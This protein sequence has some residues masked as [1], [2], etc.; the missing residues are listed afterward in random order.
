MQRGEGVSIEGFVLQ[1]GQRRSGPANEGWITRVTGVDTGGLVTIGE[2]VI[3]PRTSGPSLHVHSR[4]DEVYLVRHGVLTVQLGDEWFE[5]PADGLAW[6]PRGIPHAFANLADEPV[7]LNG[8]IL[9]AGLERMF[10]ELAD[11]M[12]GVAGPPDASR[13]GEIEARYGMRTVGPP[14]SARRG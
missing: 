14:I 4:E 2:A 3:P 11:E 1:P 7:R 5:V 12:S 13:I 9:P 8:L 6:L 10:A